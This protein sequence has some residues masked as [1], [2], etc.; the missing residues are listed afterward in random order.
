MPRAIK[1]AKTRGKDLL[2]LGNYKS[3]R[4]RH[5]YIRNGNAAIMF[6]YALTGLA[7]DSR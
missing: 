3:R 7:E 1:A 2:V 5:S 6:V 4:A